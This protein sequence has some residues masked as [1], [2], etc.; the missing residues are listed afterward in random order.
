MR[1]AG[2]DRFL[3]L[4]SGGGYPGLPLALALPRSQAVL[5]DSVAKKTAFLATVV[6]A[7]GLDDRVGVVRARA[8]DLVGRAQ[9]GTTP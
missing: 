3:D 9:A 7:T 4:G 6:T 2:V 1:D 5:I 8:E